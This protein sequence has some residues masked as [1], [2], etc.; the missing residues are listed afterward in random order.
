MQTNAMD[1]LDMILEMIQ[2]LELQGFPL[3]HLGWLD[4]ICLRP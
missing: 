2:V 3:L 4:G 1:S